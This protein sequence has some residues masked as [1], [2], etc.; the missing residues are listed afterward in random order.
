MVNDQSRPQMSEQE[1]FNELV[2]A[3]ENLLALPWTAADHIGGQRALRGLIREISKENYQEEGRSFT[4]EYPMVHCRYIYSVSFPALKICD[5]CLRKL[6][7]SE[8]FARRV[9]DFYFELMMGWSEEREESLTKFDLEPDDLVPACRFLVAKQRKLLLDYARC[10]KE[11]KTR[12]EAFDV[13]SR[14][15]E[16]VLHCPSE[17]RAVAENEPDEAVRAN[18]M[19]L[20]EDA[21]MRFDLHTEIKRA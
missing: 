11:A 15:P 19:E 16:I 4:F 18:M 1:L 12:S 13:L 2:S 20:L 7:P 6:G 14:V 10:G 3:H 17:V 21:V 9:F 5:F 8:R